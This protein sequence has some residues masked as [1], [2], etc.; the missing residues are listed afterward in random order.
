[1]HAFTGADMTTQ[2]VCFALIFFVPAMGLYFYRSKSIP[3][4]KKKKVHTVANSGCSWCLVLF[5]S[6]LIITAKTSI[7]VYNKI[8]GTTCH[9]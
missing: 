5:L 3:S 7:P 8:F 9:A 6:A 1:V 4:I 2:L